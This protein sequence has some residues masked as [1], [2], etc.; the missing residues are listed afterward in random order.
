MKKAAKKAR[1]KTGRLFDRLRSSPRSRSQ[2][3]AP[4]RDLNVAPQAPLP[5]EQLAETESQ[6]VQ[7]IAG[8]SAVQ[9]SSQIVEAPQF[10]PPDQGPISSAQFLDRQDDASQEAEPPTIENEGSLINEVKQL[11]RLPSN[12][13]SSG[14]GQGLVRLFEGN[15][16]APYS[17]TLRLFSTTIKTQHTTLAAMSST[18]IRSPTTYISQRPRSVL[19]QASTRDTHSFIHRKMFLKRSKKVRTLKALSEVTLMRLSDRK[20]VC[21]CRP[22]R[23]SIR[24]RGLLARNSHPCTFDVHQVGSG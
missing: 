16:L 11:R 23:S 14:L 1:E 9:L 5:P 15:D 18:T 20:T 2:S 17:S 22:A 13:S 12:L 8:P 4:D 3:P 6:P 7:A 10:V 19:C 21:S 24:R